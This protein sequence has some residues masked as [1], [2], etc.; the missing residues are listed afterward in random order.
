MALRALALVALSALLLAPVV[1]AHQAAYSVDNKYRFSVGHLNEPITTYVKTGL[2][3]SLSL[4]DAARTAV[5]Q[6][7][8][9]NLTA[10]LTAPDGSTL[11]LPLQN[12]FGTVNHFTFTEPYVLTQG[13]VYRLKVTGNVFGSAVA[14]ENVA[15]GSTTPVP[16]MSNVT[17]PAS[18][19]ASNLELQDE[20]AALKARIAALESAPKAK[21]APSLDAMPAL[22]L[23][24]AAVAVATRRRA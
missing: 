8:P 9:G 2:D 11:S 14:F 5:P 4:N 19:V 12:Q 24:L 15:V 7:N 6:L 22:V 13:G 23:L 20:V 10:T 18:K 3:L 16:A 1:S 21:G 17:F